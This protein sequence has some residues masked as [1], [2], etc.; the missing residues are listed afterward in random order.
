MSRNATFSITSFLAATVLA[1]GAVAAATGYASADETATC[2]TPLSASESS[3]VQGVQRDLTARF[4]HAS[5]AIAAGY[6]RYTNPDDTGA[7]SYANRQWNADPSHPSQLF[8]D[9]SGN[10]MGADFSVLR[11]NNEPRPQLW[12]VD[13]CRWFEFNGHV[14]YVVHDPSNGKTYYDQYVWNSDWVAAGGSLSSPSASTL[15]AMKKVPNES[16]VVTIFEMPTIWDLI[17]WVK[18]HGPNQLFW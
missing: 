8:Y 10:L 6:V 1:A 11:P 15:V 3:F 12:G 18:P 13:P 14:H 2:R 9:T 17:V 4:A 16:Y 5:D 7:I